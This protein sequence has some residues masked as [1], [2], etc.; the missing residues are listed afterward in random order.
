MNLILESALKRAFSQSNFSIFIMKFPAFTL[1]LDKKDKRK[2]LFKLQ[3]KLR[4]FDD[5]ALWSL[6][7]HFVSIVAWFVKKKRLKTKHLGKLVKMYES[8]I[9]EVLGAKQV[10]EFEAGVNELVRIVFK[11]E[12]LCK[13]FSVRLHAFSGF[14][15]SYPSFGNYDFTHDSWK[16]KVFEFYLLFSTFSDVSLPGNHALINEFKDLFTCLWN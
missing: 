12:V 10:R 1:K 13:A 2:K 11:S 14:G 8:G 6:D 4:G 3:R 5:T 15:G 9:A 16:K 7:Y